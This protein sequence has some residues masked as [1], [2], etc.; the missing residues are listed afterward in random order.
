MF[1]SGSRMNFQNYSTDWILSPKA[2][3]ASKLRACTEQAHAHGESKGHP[4]TLLRPE[5]VQARERLPSCTNAHSQSHRDAMP[6]HCSS[7]SRRCP[8]TF[9]FAL[10]ASHPFQPQPN[11]INYIKSVLEK[12]CSHHVITPLQ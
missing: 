6:S 5:T 1:L 2:M 11:L 4:N 9:G 8:H 7:P 10:V 12:T 3:Q